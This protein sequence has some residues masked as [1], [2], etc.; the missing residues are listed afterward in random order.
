MFGFIKKMFIVLFSVCTI[1]RFGESL[2]FNSKGPIKCISLNNQPYQ[3]KPGLVDI[4]SNETLIGKE[5]VAFGVII[6]LNAKVKVI[7]IKHY[8][9]KNIL[10]KL[11]HT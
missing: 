8:H 6:I 10:R 3:T 9:L 5:L 2:A 11:N 7:E 1:G 4:I